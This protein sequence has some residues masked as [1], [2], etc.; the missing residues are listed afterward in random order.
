MIDENMATIDESKINSSWYQVLDFGT[1]IVD[2]VPRS[3]AQ[4]DTSEFNVLP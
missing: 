4:R 2:K 3:T 1:E